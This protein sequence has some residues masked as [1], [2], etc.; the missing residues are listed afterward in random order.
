V[1]T[2]EISE[3]PDLNVAGLIRRNAEKTINFDVPIQRG[4]V[5]D[6][7]RK[8]KLIHSVM[9]GIPTG[10]FWLNRLP[11]GTYEGMD[12]KQRTDTLTEFVNN[13]LTLAANLPPIIFE[14]KEVVIAKKKFSSLPEPLKEKIKGAKIRALWVDNATNEEKK[15]LFDYINSYFP[16]KPADINRIDIKSRGNFLTLVKHEGIRLWVSVK[17]CRKYQDEDI[18]EDVFC[19]ASGETNLS[20]KPRIEFLKVAVMTPD[21]EA[22]FVKALDYLLALHKSLKDD[23]KKVVVLVKKRKRGRQP[24]EDGKQIT[25]MKAKVHVSALI[26][27]AIV[28]VRKNIPEKKYIEGMRKLFT[29]TDGKA[30]ISDV[31]NE[32]CKGGTAK[33][34]Q[35]KARMAEIE[36]ML[37]K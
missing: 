34:P 25:K 12:G 17:N 28:A 15:L 20:A 19:M 37:G 1:F 8:S 21:Q 11:D 10:D 9:I 16:M 31:Y 6:T 3:L 14:G 22:E 26:Y 35:V 13:R 5:W 23:E 36:K 30:T 33:E 27:G 32:A 24:N 7:K 2:K 4:Y 18:L 29:T